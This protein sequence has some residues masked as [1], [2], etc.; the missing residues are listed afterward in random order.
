MLI[1]QI[2][3]EMAKHGGVGI[4]EQLSRSQAGRLAAHLAAADAAHA[5]AKTRPMTLKVNHAG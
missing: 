4:A 1:D 3:N 2:A 5:A